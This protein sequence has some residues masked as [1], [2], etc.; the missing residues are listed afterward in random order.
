MA[1]EIFTLAILGSAD[2]PETTEDREFS[3]GE[4][5][6]QQ[7]ALIADGIVAVGQDDDSLKIALALHGFVEWS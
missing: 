2:S 4:H 1:E 5:G 7:G 3:A 6:G